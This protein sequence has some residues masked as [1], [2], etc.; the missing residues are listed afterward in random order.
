VVRAIDF[1]VKP[2]SKGA[3]ADI[4]CARGWH[5]FPGR[6][7]NPDSERESC[8]R[9]KP[10]IVL[11]GEFQ[12]RARLIFNELQAAWSTLNWE[13]ARPHETDNIFQMHQL[14]DRSVQKTGTEECPGPVPNTFDA[15]G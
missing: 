11:V 9:T 10:P 3:A 1:A 2:G 6:L 13:R 4:G 8:V 14:L 12:A 5:G 15:A 7:F